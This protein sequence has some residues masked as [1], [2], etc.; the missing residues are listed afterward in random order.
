M[1]ERTAI[2]IR[3]RAVE[4][5]SVLTNA[6]DVPVPV[7]YHQVMRGLSDLRTAWFEHRRVLSQ[8]GMPIKSDIADTI[9]SLEG[10]SS[11]GWART[12]ELGLNALRL[13]ATTILRS[14]LCQLE[15]EREVEPVRQMSIAA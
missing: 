9:F 12:P 3:Q 14:L 1:E 10:M 7:Q 8:V 2:V 5:L 11:A 4:T 6:K 15:K 13:R